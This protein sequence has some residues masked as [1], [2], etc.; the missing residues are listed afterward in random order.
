MR[1]GATRGAH[2]QLAAG[3]PATEPET[4]LFCLHL[5]AAANEAYAEILG[6]A[7]RSEV[8]QYLE[9]RS[10]TEAVRLYEN[11]LRKIL[12]TPAAGPICVIGLETGR[13][14]GWRVAV[15]GAGRQLRRRRNGVR[16]T[17]R[18][19]KGNAAC[20]QASRQPANG[21]QATSAKPPDEKAHEAEPDAADVPTES[22]E[23]TVA[24]QAEPDASP[25]K[26]EPNGARAFDRGQ[27]RLPGRRSQVRL[28][29]AQE[30]TAKDDA[31]GAASQPIESSTAGGG[32]PKRRKQR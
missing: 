9:E 3:W 4:S 29:K 16:R 12:L 31:N 2:H 28:N 32:S 13:S 7:F 1:S 11:N 22:V 24:L 8:L 20:R 5:E 18:E 14:G 21:K 25:V 30:A 26:V 23:P 15:V 27:T 19:T 6:P 17:G 10:D